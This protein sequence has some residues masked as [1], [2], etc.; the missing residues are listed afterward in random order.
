MLQTIHITNNVREKNAIVA[1][2]HV[3]QPIVTHFWLRQT[4][5]FEVYSKKYTLLLMKHN[6]AY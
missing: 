3:F 1:K 2:W 6:A 5:F 4:Y